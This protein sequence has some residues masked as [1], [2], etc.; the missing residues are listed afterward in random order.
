M[1][2]QTKN[3]FTIVEMMVA[4]VLATIIAGAIIL[5]YIMQSQKLT[6]STAHDIMQIQFD[7]F[8]EAFSYDVRYSNRI[9]VPGVS[10][11]WTPEIKNDNT[12]TITTKTISLFNAEGVD[13]IRYNFQGTTIKRNNKDFQTGVGAILIDLDKSNFIITENRR[14]V[15]IDLV[16]K[17]DGVHDTYFTNSRTG[18]LSCRN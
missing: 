11:A 17:I 14:D 2:V 8:M 18:V 4:I 7:N 1:K 9:L 15:K 16:I 6:E 3:G 10:E 12:N 5:V 13:T